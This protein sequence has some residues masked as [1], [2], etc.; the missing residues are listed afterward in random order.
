MD[1]SDAFTVES[2]ESAGVLLDDDEMAELQLQIQLETEDLLD[3]AGVEET[4]TR[5]A[6]VHMIGGVAG[7]AFLAGRAFE[8]QYHSMSTTFPVDM[9]PQVLQEFLSFLT[10]R[11]GL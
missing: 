11:G 9:E 3:E 7:R 1:I 10:Q 6:I 5:A 2:I 8:T 4:A